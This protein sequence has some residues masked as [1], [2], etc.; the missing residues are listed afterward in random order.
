MIAKLTDDE[1]STF[2]GLLASLGEGDG[3]AAADFALQF[4]LE[5]NFTESERDDFRA[6]MVEMFAERC[7]GYGTNVDVGH[8]L[9]G[10]LGLIRKHHVRIDANYATLV[11]NVLCVESLA[12]DVCPGYNV[13]DAAKPLLRAYRNLCYDKTGEPIPGARQSR[14]V[15]ARLGLEY[16]RKNQNDKAFFSKVGRCRQQDEKVG[17]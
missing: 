4:S 10:V 14:L 9:R 5:N 2:I 8:V 12:R 15:K 6:D 16:F 11:V 17:V 1:S 13:L 7:Q 3:E